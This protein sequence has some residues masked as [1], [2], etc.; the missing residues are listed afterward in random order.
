[1]RLGRAAGDGKW[2]AEVQPGWDIFEISNGGYLASIAARA[3]SDAAGGRLPVTVTTH[4]T[5]PVSAGPAELTVEMVKEGRNFST[6]SAT[7][8]GSSAPSRPGHL[9]PPRKR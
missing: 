5:R 1:M 7:L 4:F 9:G 2:R 8:T 3:M 6:V